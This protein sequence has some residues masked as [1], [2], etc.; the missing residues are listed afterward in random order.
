MSNQQTELTLTIKQSNKVKR[1]LKAL[2]EVRGEI[3]GLSENDVIWYFEAEGSIY[4]MDGDTHDSAES[5][6]HSM[7]IGSWSLPNYDCGGW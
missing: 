7:I 3:D 2:E 1:A 6:N 4:L 5:A